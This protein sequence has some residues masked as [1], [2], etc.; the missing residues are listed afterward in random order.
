MA[1]IRSIHPG[2]YTDEAWSSVS[3]A[4]RW[5]AMGLC[6][7]A[8]DLGVFEW[9]PIQIKMRVY[10]ANNEDIP[11]LL[12]ELQAAGIV[13]PFDVEGKRYGAVRNFCKYQRPRKPKSWFPITAGIRLFVSEAS[14]VSQKSEP[15]DDDGGPVPQKSGKPPQM[16]DGGWRM[17]GETN[18]QEK[19]KDL[20]PS[21]RSSEP[22]PP[23]EPD[24][25]P[26][27]IANLQ[28]LHPGLDV[29]G[30]M[31]EL[32]EW[33]TKKGIVRRNERRSAIGATLL[34]RQQG[35]EGATV[36]AELRQT[37]PP[38]IDVSPALSASK[39]ARNGRRAH[40]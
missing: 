37:G 26:K 15:D 9:K 39:L 5:L 31:P 38:A 11:A 7:E 34:K 35:L 19:N 10:P 23:S 24:F 2:V 29:A 30:L 14:R 3:V 4:A 6:T 13:M 12:A 8:D 18:E 1:R 36:L 16:E 40:P 25:S 20:E 28:V 17:E 22:V 27:E 21:V 32:A 33:A